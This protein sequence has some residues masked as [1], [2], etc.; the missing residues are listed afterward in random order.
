MGILSIYWGKEFLCLR[1]HDNTCISGLPEDMQEPIMNIPFHSLL[2]FKVKHI[3][4]WINLK[5][6][7]VL[8]QLNLNEER[9]DNNF[10][11]L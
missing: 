9:Q 3:L 7:F 6:T 2:Y 1:N 11:G 4:F 10:A 8:G 5:Y